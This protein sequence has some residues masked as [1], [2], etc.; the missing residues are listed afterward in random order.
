MV[1]RLLALVIV[2]IVVLI[3]GLFV[4]SGERLA[5]IAGDQITSMSGRQVTLGG[6]L[7]PQ[8]FPNLGVRTGAFEIAG[9]NGDAPLISG[10]GLSVGVDLWALV[11]RRVDVKEITL[12]APNVRLVKD[13]K[14]RVNWASDGAGDAGATS[15]DGSKP[16]DISLAALSIQDG[17]LLFQDATSGVDLL[18]QSI[19]VTASMPSADAPLTAAL[20]FVAAGQSASADIEVASLA[21]LIAGS[22]SSVSLDAQVGDNTITFTGNAA[23]DGALSGDFAASLPAPSALMALSGGDAAALP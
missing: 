12:V 3:G 11:K 2:L 22:A 6:S 1:L 16:S 17:T 15:A 14:G 21:A 7:R 4:I 19:D 23:S 13:S 18:L 8:L 20:S 9:T 5:K 10:E